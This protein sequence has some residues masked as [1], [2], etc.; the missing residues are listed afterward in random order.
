MSA[1]LIWKYGKLEPGFA[2]ADDAHHA[3]TRTARYI[4]HAQTL[5]IKSETQ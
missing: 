2:G 1:W 5:R 3:A 4:K